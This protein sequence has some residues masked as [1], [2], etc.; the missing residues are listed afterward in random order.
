[1]VNPLVNVINVEVNY[2][3]S[4]YVVIMKIIVNSIYLFIK[5]KIGKTVL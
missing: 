4:V 2:V 1:M 5:F 3:L